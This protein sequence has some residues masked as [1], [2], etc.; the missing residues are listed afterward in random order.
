MIVETRFFAFGLE[1]LIKQCLIP[2]VI[3]NSTKGKQPCPKN[4]SSMTDMID[5]ASTKGLI[6]M[7]VLG[8]CYSAVSMKVSIS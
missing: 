2:A 3:I 4:K 1:P 8:F 6:K 5:E 7:L